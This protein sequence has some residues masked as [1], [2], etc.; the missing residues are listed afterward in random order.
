[1]VLKV[2]VRPSIM[3]ASL[4]LLLFTLLLA[5]C[6]PRPPA[7]R[8]S[9]VP[10]NAT[11]D[12]GTPDP[13]TGESTGY[14][15]PRY[16]YV[17]TTELPGMDETT[18]RRILHVD[19]SA[20]PGG[21]GS[22]TSPFH[23]IGA[24]HQALHAS[25]AE[26][27]PT[28]LRIAPGVYREDVRQLLNF[29]NASPTAK[30]TL[31]VVEGAAPGGVILSGAIEQHPGLG[32]FRPET[33]RAVPGHPGLYV[34]DWPFPAFVDPGP[35]MDSY[36]F[37]LL[38]GLMQRA[39]MIWVNGTHM[40]QVLAE[41]YR[42]EDPDGKR[43]FSDMGTGQGGDPD[44]QPGKLVFE[45]RLMQ[46]P[47]AEL[48]EPGT[49]A[50]FTAPEVKDALSGKVYLRLPDGLRMEE[51]GSLE[52]GHWK[53][54]SYSPMLIVRG[55]ENLIL[56]NLAVRHGSM[57]PM[58]AA[59]QMN[60][61][62]NFIVEDC[63]FSENVASGLTLKNSSR[64]MFRRVTALHNGSNGLNFG[65]S[66]QILLEDC[67]T[68]F[69]NYRGGWAGWVGWHASGFKSGGVRNITVRRHVSVGNYANGIWYDVYCKDV[70][71]EDSLIYGN[72]RMGV[73]FEL[74]R[75]KGGP[76]VLRNSIAAE[77]DN[78]GVY[79]TMAANSQVEDNLVFR[80]GGGAFVEHD[81]SKQS[82]LL[83]K[84]RDHP[85]GPNS[86]EAWQSVTIT[87]NWFLSDLPG[88]RIIDYLQNRSEPLT[89]FDRVLKVL[90]SRDNRYGSRETAAFHLPD[91]QWADL[92][93][94][95]ALL[96]E[97][98]APVPD[99]GSVWQPGGLDAD[100]RRELT[101]ASDSEV[102]RRA[103]AMGVPL[104]PD[105]LAEYWK[106]TDQGFYQPPHLFYEKQH[107]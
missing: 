38:P 92:E 28:K 71:V 97:K 53:G 74:T 12:P 73:M 8:P 88:S 10:V 31:L 89:Q 2:P 6:T 48:T 46:D 98:Q 64:G 65:G 78:T 81:P 37:A 32:D 95:K 39:E 61:C 49:F 1:M 21:D 105:S 77:N 19:G 4:R 26:G 63:D 17:A 84:F 41:R 90:A 20:A 57:G 3:N 67:E 93:D 80:N 50:V 94:W 35:W 22:E 96:E 62:R 34:H 24:A 23:R 58:T 99:T 7:P 13:G 104:A 82:Q 69:N 45:R 100:R 44:N 59:V 16:D 91:G 55:K 14:T 68:S 70:L 15:P 33:W 75:P 60:E 40:R 43:G 9:D 27:V 103:R 52:I 72:K 47:A 5:G 79:L 102:S 25:L 56:R 101:A 107:D 86:P 51:V 87:R 54:R 30:S 11:R 76:H 18:L 83:Y 106:R 36:G 42:W 85:Q 29:S 66:S